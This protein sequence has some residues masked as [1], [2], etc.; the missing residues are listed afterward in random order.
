MDTFRHART[1]AAALLA[2]AMSSACGSTSSSGGSP[3]SSNTAAGNVAGHSYAAKDAIFTTA[4]STSGFSLGTGSVTVIS[5]ESGAGACAEQQSAQAVV[6]LDVDMALAQVDATGNT[7]PISETGTYAVTTGTPGS[8][9]FAQAVFE[10]LCKMANLSVAVTQ[11]T[12]GSVTVTEVD[13]SHVAGTLDLTFGT[14][15]VTGSFYASNCSAFDVNK[16]LC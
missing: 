2:L 16:T 13:S 6:T 4:S 3:S 8:G 7:T 12:G 10:P 15:R 11:A 9:L 14:D 5:I 1:A